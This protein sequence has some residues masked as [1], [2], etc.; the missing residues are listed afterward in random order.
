VKDSNLQPTDKESVALIEESM[1][2][3]EIIAESKELCSSASKKFENWTL[4]HPFASFT[5]KKP[6]L[7]IF[8][9]PVEV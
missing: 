1:L 2:S 6:K 8:K 4:A 9:M 3:V 7:G 5:A